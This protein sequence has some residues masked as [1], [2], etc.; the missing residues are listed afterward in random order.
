MMFT[1]DESFKND[2]IFKFFKRLT[3]QY[4]FVTVHSIFLKLFETYPKTISAQP[5]ENV[6]VHLQEV[7]YDRARQKCG[8][9]KDK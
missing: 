6:R 9:Y 8:S 2:I 7:R 1:L 5:S 3:F 4:Q